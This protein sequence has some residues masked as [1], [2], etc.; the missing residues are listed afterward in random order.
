MKNTSQNSVNTQTWTNGRHDV[1]CVKVIDETFDARTYCFTSTEPVIHF[2]K[3]GQF[4]TLELEIDGI[5]VLRS[6]TISSSPSVPYSFSITV[7]RMSGG[8]VSNWLHDNLKQGDQIAVHGPV[9]LF[10]CIDITADKVLL[11]SGGVGITPVMSMARWWFDTNGEVDMIFAHSARTPKDIIY[12]REL[13]YMDSRITNFDLNFICERYDIGDSWSGFSGF[14]DEQKLRMIA[15]DFLDRTVYCCGP[16][17]YMKAVKSMLERIGFN[18]ENYHE[19]SFGAPPE[20]AQLDAEQQAEDAAGESVDDD[21]LIE[22]AFSKT[23]KS[24]KIQP[25][26]TVHLAAS[27]VGLHIPKACGMGICGTCKVKK[28]KGEVVMSH[29]G[30]ITDEDVADGYILS[31]CS[32]P[33]GDVSVEY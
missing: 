25:G 12:R 6:Y 29:N 13:E 16:T 28:I 22:I 21:T 18:M 3:P 33:Q 2:F 27:Q 14:F 10:N 31:C 7:K 24:I 17:P 1:Q 32:V 15:P 11:L 20:E 23:G 4:V 30:G 19:E 9:G 26:G 8:Q 5:Q